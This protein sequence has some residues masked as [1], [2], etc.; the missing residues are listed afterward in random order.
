MVRKQTATVRRSAIEHS[1]YWPGAGAERW[2]MRHSPRMVPGMKFFSVPVFALVCLIGVPGTS[3]AADLPAGH[4]DTVVAIPGACEE[5]MAA[6][7]PTKWVGTGILYMHISNGI[8]LF[9]VDIDGE[10][11][12]AFVGE[13]DSQ[14]K[15]SE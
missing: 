1:S 8:A 2:L 12:M 6:N 7:V 13:K 15:P 10:K 11:M 3:L 4:V 9:E 14:P 5:V